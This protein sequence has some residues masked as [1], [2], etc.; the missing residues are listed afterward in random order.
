M[1]WLNGD[2]FTS[3]PQVALTA[4]VRQKPRRECEVRL[5]GRLTY[6]LFIEKRAQ[7]SLSRIAAKDRDR[8]SDAI[9]CLADDPRPRGVKKLTGKGCLANSRR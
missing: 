1:R 5:S 8:I 4:A 7:R 9:R 6:A 2:G 3:D